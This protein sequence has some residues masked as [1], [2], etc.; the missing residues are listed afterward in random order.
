MLNLNNIYEEMIKFLQGRFNFTAEIALILGS[1]L[2]DFADNLEVLDSISTSDIPG[3]PA[4]TVVGHRGKILFAKLGL[5]NVLLFQGRIHYYEGYP[6]HQCVLPVF[7]AH[8]FGCK[9][10][11]LT[12]AAGGINPNFVPGDLMLINSVN[13]MGLKNDL[14]HLIGYAN[15]DSI[16]GIRNFQLSSV[17]KKIQMAAVEEKIDLKDGVYWYSKGPSYETPAEI[18]MMGKFGGD[19]VGMST[20][21]E[22]IYAI[23]LGM[24]TGSISCITNFAAGISD[25]KLSH[26]EVTETANMVKNKF[27]R[28]IKKSI[29]L[30]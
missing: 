18:K 20:V 27:E 5:K 10:I 14:S 15:A 26:A 16:T 3:Y 21:H 1:G 22:Q 9:K 24:E 11:I 13:S 17:Y 2:G 6:I 8:K 12:N 7:I 29:E 4:S 28:L 19:A 23:T 25:Q 30:I